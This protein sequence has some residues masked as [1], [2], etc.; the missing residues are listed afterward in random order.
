MSK[1]R[2]ALLA[3]ALLIGVGI[4]IA[5][6]NLPQGFGLQMVAMSATAIRRQACSRG[7]KEREGWVKLTHMVRT[8]PDMVRGPLKVAQPRLPLGEIASGFTCPQ[9]PVASRCSRT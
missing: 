2:S 9:A 1:S 4:V 5:T 7:G 8:P 6:G 3:G